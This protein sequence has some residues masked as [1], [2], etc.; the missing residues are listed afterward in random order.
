MIDIQRSG[1]RITSALAYRFDTRDIVRIR[2]GFVL[3]ATETGELLP[4]AKIP[5]TVGSEAKAETGEPHA[6]PAANPAC[7]QSFTYT[8]AVDYTPAAENK[9]P[10]AIHIRTDPRFPAFQPAGELSGGVRWRGSFDYTVFGEDPPIPNNMSPKPFFPWRRLVARKNFTGENAPEDL[11]LMNWPRQ[12]YHEESLLDRT[13]EDTAR[14]LQAA[15]NVSMSFL[16]WLQNDVPRDDG[17]GKGYPG[18]RLRKDVMESADGLSKYPYI[19]ESR[20][21]QAQ[22]RVAEQI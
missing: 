18:F 2:P 4:I 1:E 13:P 10:K 12:D 11:A 20:R 3:D 9:I 14:I 17:N 7:V 6:A 15:K 5:Y 19:R 22:G 8:F 21:M 16:Y